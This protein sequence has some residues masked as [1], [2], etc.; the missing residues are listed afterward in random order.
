MAPSYRAHPRL[1]QDEGREW[2]AARAEAEAQGTFFMAW[3]HHCVVG[4]KP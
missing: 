4:K 1:Y 2:Q 3:P